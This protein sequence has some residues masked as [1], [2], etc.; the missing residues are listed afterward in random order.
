M[1]TSVHI[2]DDFSAQQVVHVLNWGQNEIHEH[3]KCSRG[4]AKAK[5][6]DIWLEQ[7]IACLGHH[8]PRKEGAIALCVGL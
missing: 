6:H 1:P 2:V 7:P 5:I 4:I 3:L 8:A